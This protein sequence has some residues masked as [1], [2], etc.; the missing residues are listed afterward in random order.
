MLRF[1]FAVLLALAGS[2]SCKGG[3]VIKTSAAYEVPME[4]SE[5][6][7]ELL[8]I[9][10]EHAA[11]FGFHVDHATDEELALQS[12]VTPTTLSAA[13]WAGTNDDESIASAMNRPYD[14]GRIWLTFN[15]GQN[16]EQTARFRTSLM[17]EVRTLWPETKEL[18]VLNGETIPLPADLIVDGDRY[19]L[20]P[21]AADR[22]NV[23]EGPATVQTPS[24]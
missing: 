10:E 23:P 20:D 11:R 22:Y 8:A 24:S 14:S 4:T 21:S 7:K 18:P 16:L 15:V 1:H 5:E 19:I 17:E 6:R 3:E 13:V 2:A 12:E 9:M